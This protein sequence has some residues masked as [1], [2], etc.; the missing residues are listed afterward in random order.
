MR[1]VCSWCQRDLGEKEPFEDPAITSTVCRGCLGELVTPEMRGLLVVRRDAA[2]LYS[3]F[4][5]LLKDRPE[6][7]VILD[8]RYGERRSSCLPVADERRSGDRRREGM[9]ISVEGIGV[10]APGILE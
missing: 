10:L 1:R 2:S 8:R 7:Q 3:E 9:V 4:L 6:V 5:E